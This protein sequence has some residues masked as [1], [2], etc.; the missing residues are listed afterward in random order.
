MAEMTQ[1]TQGHGWEPDRG[2]TAD[3]VASLATRLGAR[4]WGALAVLCLGS[5]V[6][7]L[8]TTIVNIAIPNVMAN[9][10]TGLDQVLWVLNGYT[11]VYAALLV[12]GG[13]LGDLYGPRRLL[14][15]GITVFV[16]ASLA[17]SL[18]QTG[19]Q[20][21]AARV[22]QGVGGAL[23]TPQT[24]ALIPAV[25]PAHRRGAA[26]GLWSGSAGLAAAIG[27]TIGGLLV[28][29]LGW[30][31]IFLVNV[32]VGLAGIAG[33]LVLL[34][35]VNQGRRHR[36]DF[37]GVLLA[38]AGLFAVVFALVE[39]Q[40]YGWGAVAGQL[41]VPE[42]ALIGVAVL[43]VFVV[44]EHRQAEPLLP[45]QLFSNRNYAISAGVIATFQ[46]V[47]YS[48]VV[49]NS[50]FLQTALSM[51]ALDAGLTLMPLPLAVMLSGP[52]AGRLTD[53]VDPKFVLMAGLLV[54]AAGLSWL[55]AVTSADAGPTTFVLPLLVAGAG[56]GTG[57]GVVMA[58]GMRDVPRQLGGAASGVLNAFRQVGG[59]MGGAI[60]AALLQNQLAGAPLGRT[61]AAGARLLYADTFVAG[62]RLTLGVPVVVV[63]AAALS[64]IWVRRRTAFAAAQHI[65]R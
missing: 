17:C 7:V 26:I 1:T 43:V 21:I 42:V 40:R 60:T 28:T 14:I 49:T 65:L 63:L 12:T 39:G 59:A 33:A 32:P 64:C 36:V 55:V 9:L 50:L 41:T 44:W 19:M 24:L 5:F 11:L 34:P 6:V 54:A 3:T 51:T 10:H 38:T 25:F 57:F 62:V 23:L 31:S 29:S 58:L 53:R 46:L 22:I 4:T 30:R 56:L 61:A 27:P 20:L 15:A 16:G 2:R 35:A 47:V 45:L 48:F 8:D 37:G 18:A 52:I 13:R